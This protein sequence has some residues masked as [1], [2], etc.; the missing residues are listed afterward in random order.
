[1]VD[2]RDGLPGLAFR[3]QAVGLADTLGIPG[4]RRRG[5]S[6]RADPALQ[7]LLEGLRVNGRLHPLESRV[8]WCAIDLCATVEAAAK[9]FQILLQQ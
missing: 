4:Q 9:G 7:D 3:P 1:M 8:G 5:L 6:P 2:Q